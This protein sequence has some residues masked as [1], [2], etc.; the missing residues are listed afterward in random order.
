[1]NFLVNSCGLRDR[2]RYLAAKS[3]RI[4]PS[5]PMDQRVYRGF[6][7]SERHCRL[8]IAAM[9]FFVSAWEESLE[10]LENLPFTARNVMR[11]H[12]GHG[13]VQQGQ[14]PASVKELLRAQP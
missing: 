11:L 6:A 7:N 8:M 4:L 5:Q 9:L 10:S 13:S 2:A 1:M 3:N 14:C 12:A